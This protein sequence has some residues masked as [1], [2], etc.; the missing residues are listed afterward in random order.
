MVCD[1][2]L[3]PYDGYCYVGPSWLGSKVIL[4]LNGDNIFFNYYGDSILI[5]T[6]AGLHEKWKLWSGD[7]GS[8]IEAEITGILLESFLEI[9]DSVKSIII[10]QYASD[11]SIINDFGGSFQFKLSKSYGLISVYNFRDFPGNQRNE[12]IAIHELAG[13]SKDKLGLHILTLGEVYHYEIGDEFHTMENRYITY[14]GRRQS[15]K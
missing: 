1:D 9:Q 3:N 10:I 11:G 15:T 7:D 4:K 2:N 13:C 14:S 5:K 12:Q 8:Y 6:R